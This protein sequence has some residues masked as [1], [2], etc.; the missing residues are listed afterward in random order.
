MLAFTRRD[1]AIWQVLTTIFMIVLFLFSFH[2][3]GIHGHYT[4]TFVTF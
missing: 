3:L 4:T 2:S 1:L